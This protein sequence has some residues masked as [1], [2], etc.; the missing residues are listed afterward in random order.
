[1]AVTTHSKLDANR[2]RTDFAYLE[3][4]VNVG[5]E[6]DRTAEEPS[7]D[8][9]LQQIA[10]LADTDNLRDDEGLVTL[11][12]LHNA[13][14]L[15]FPIVFMIGVEEGVF[16]HSRALDEGGLEE[17]RRLAYVG[18]TRAQRDLYVTW[19]RARNLFFL[20]PF[21]FPWRRILR[22]IICDPSLVAI[23]HL[24]SYQTC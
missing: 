2:V 5:H 6:Y 22:Q 10:L 21:S 18:I 4:L 23:Q 20:V 12:T 16:P 1:M 19:A 17:E 9:F 24:A 13:K 7:L 15:E 11:M 3:E 8:G 14:G